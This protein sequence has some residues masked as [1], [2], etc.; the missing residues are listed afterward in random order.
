MA[1][2]L[3]YAGQ[4][5]AF[6]GGVSDGSFA[7]TATKLKLYA[8]S[9]TPAKD[10]TGF[11]EVSNGNGYVTGGIAITRAN[12]TAETDSLNRR[13]RLADQT[14]TASGGSIANIGGAYVTDAADAVLAWWERSTP[15]TIA[16]GDTFTADDLYIKPT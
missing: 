3:T 16:S 2:S 10:G 5:A 13:I 11:T 1:N 8:S 4:D 9:S 12:W 6:Y 14:W 7:R 15:I